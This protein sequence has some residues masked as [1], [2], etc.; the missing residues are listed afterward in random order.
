M[1]IFA[2]ELQG[3]RN[4][5]EISEDELTSRVFG[6]L[7]IIDRKILRSV[8]NYCNIQITEDDAKKLKIDFWQEYHAVSEK[9]GVEPDIILTLNKKLLVYIECKLESRGN[10]SQLEEEYRIGKE[11][12]SNKFHLVYLTNTLTTP[13]EV[14][15]AEKKLKLETETIRWVNWIKIYEILDREKSS[16]RAETTERKLLEDLIN[17]LEEMNMAPFQK[18]MEEYKKQIGKGRG[19]IVK[20]YEMLR[21]F[22]RD[23]LRK[24]LKEKYSNEYIV[25]DPH[26]GDLSDRLSWIDFTPK[27]WAEKGM[28]FY[29]R[30][31]HDTFEWE[32]WFGVRRKPCREKIRN[33]LAEKKLK[34]YILNDKELSRDGVVSYHI[35]SAP[36]FDDAKSLINTIHEKIEQFI[37]VMTSVMENYKGN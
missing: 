20:A 4:C 10:A 22:L 6:V 5:E 28:Y 35:T 1:S 24:S 9:K 13:L 34:N 23:D 32:I 8:L 12:G 17:L 2:A 15:E 14:N 30:F 31:S 11:C 26:Y 18:Y 29:I 27:K 33:F 37:N 16:I 25:S 19:D 21:K 7:D 36:N 3:K